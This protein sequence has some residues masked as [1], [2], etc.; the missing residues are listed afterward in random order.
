MSITY[1]SPLEWPIGWPRSKN[2]VSGNRRYTRKSHSGYMKPW[3]I[4][5]A[6]EELF[7]ELGRL[8]A[9]DCI[10]T[11]NLAIRK[12]GMISG[13]QRYDED[14]GVA[15]YF[16]LDGKPLVMAND[17]FFEPQN[18]IRQLTIALQNLRH[19]SENGGAIMKQR[20]FSGFSA[21][22]A[23]MSGEEP[24]YSVLN[25]LPDE[26]LTEAKINTRYRKMAKQHHSDTGGE[27]GRMAALNVARDR[28]LA[29]LPQSPNQ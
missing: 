24:Y 9:K 15:V 22:P 20:A 27:D 18:N 26:E 4:N 7:K 14:M 12:D 25:F 29:S 11:S 1:K 5:S 13:N 21:L 8:G 10:V 3:P 23:P 2:R 28:A 19:L 6:G 16:S 17:T